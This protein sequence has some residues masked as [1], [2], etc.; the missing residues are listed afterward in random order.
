MFRKYYFSPGAEGMGEMGVEYQFGML[1]RIWKEI[2][3]MIRQHR[4]HT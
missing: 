1:K 4:E 3:V 2:V